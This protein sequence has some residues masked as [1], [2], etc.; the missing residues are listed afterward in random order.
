[1]QKKLIF[2]EFEE[3]KR[4]VFLLRAS[5]KK[6]KQYKTTKVYTPDELEYY[7]SLSFRF[8][9]S[10][11]LAL[12]FF[13]GLEIFVYAKT[14]D[15]LRDRLLIMRKINIIDDLDFWFEAR[16]LRNKIA[17]TYIVEEQKS[18]YNEI[19]KRSQIIFETITRVEK[20]LKSREKAES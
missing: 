6:F 12:N 17:H 13:K 2:Q 14:S 15:T 3:L 4:A 16:M 9:K 10:A 8:E 11:E 18:L 19:Y 7:D 20:Y 1:M 5:V